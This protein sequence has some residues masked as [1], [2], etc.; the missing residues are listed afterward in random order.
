M[1]PAAAAAGGPRVGRY[2]WVIC[3]LLFTATTVND[4]DR[5]VIGILKPTL[6]HDLGWTEIDYG[7]IVFA[8][9]L[10][11]AIGLLVVG[12]IIDWLGTKRGLSAA[13]IFWSLAAMA[14]AAVRSVAGFAA[15]RFA[16]GLSEAGNFPAAIKAVAEWFPKKERALATGIFNSGTNIGAIVAPLIVPPLTLAF[17]W[18]AAFLVTGAIGLAWLALW[19]PMYQAPDRHPRVGAA[20]LAYIT[21][22]APDSATP[23]PWRAIIGQRQAWAFA[24]AKFMT[25]PIW[26]I[27]LFWIPDFL[28]RDHQ[29]DLKSLGL[30]LIVIYLAADVGSIGGGWLSSALILRGWTVGRARTTAMFI[31]AVAVVPVAFLSEVKSLWGA[32]ALL[33]VATA[34]HQ[35]WSANL[36]TTA[37]DMF[38]RRAVAS[39]IGFGGMAGAVGGMFIAQLTGHLLELTHSYRVIFII[40]GTTYLAALGLFRWIAP[41]LDPIGSDHTPDVHSGTASSIPTAG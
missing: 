38:P 12:R 24:V 37:S 33:S 34:A 3:A 41:T 40:A 5:Q 17:G 2:R 36:F 10:A 35:G 8:F 21:S 7:N 9:Q 27:F 39:V 23:L 11:Y 16:L 32:V 30:P 4:V 26:Y 14:H 25:D 18:Q 13:L 29:V 1:T 19:I 22:D 20:E 6:Q 15:A 31:C 28:Y